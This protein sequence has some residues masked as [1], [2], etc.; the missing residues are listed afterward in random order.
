MD[1]QNKVETIAEE[2]KEMVTEAVKGLNSKEIGVLSVCAVGVGA[3]SIAL[4]EG[5]KKA[6]PK[7]KAFFKKTFGKKPVEAAPVV[8]AVQK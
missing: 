4:W 8:E 2:A 1:E 7:V 3:V 5:C 6:A